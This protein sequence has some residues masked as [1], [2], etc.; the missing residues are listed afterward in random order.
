MRNGKLMQ[1]PLANKNTARYT[2]V[3]DAPQHSF[4]YRSV[5]KPDPDVDAAAARGMAPMI[6]TPT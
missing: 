1:T 6:V 2:M 3:V 4:I 5:R